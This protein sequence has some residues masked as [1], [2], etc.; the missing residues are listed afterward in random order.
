MLASTPALARWQNASR[1]APT[2][3]TATTAPPLSTVDAN[4]P[5]EGRYTVLSAEHGG[6]RGS[7]EHWL[8]ALSISRQLMASLGK[9]HSDTPQQPGQEHMTP[10]C[11]PVPEGVAWPPVQRPVPALR[12]P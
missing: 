4:A 12:P 7:P 11:K 9:E 5:R 2:Y 8:V 3:T 10:F 6:G 1:G